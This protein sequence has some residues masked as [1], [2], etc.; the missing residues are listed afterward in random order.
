M[1]STIKNNYNYC[2][3]KQCEG[4]SLKRKRF[5]TY[6]LGKCVT[7]DIG[8]LTSENCHLIGKNLPKSC[9]F[10]SKE[11]TKTIKLKK[12][13]FGNLFGKKWLVFG[14]IGHDCGKFP[15]GQVMAS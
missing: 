15:E 8:G 1:I 2:F 5:K 13:I 6:C 9:H 12:T 3:P 14:N 7:S 4:D 11:L 10:F